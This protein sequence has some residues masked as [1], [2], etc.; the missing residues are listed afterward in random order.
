MNGDKRLDS[1][2]WE[3]AGVVGAVLLGCVAVTLLLTSARADVMLFGADSTVMPLFQRGLER[4]DPLEWQ[5]T[6]TIFAVEIPIFALVGLVFTSTYAQVLA[7]AV[8]NFVFLYAMLRMLAGIVAPAYR[9]AGRVTLA[10]AAVAVPALLVALETTQSVRTVEF[11]SMLLATSY[12]YPVLIGMFLAVALIAKMVRDAQPTA[13]A[14]LWR[15]AAL[16][17]LTAVLVT[18]NPLFAGWAVVPIALALLILLV[19]RRGVPF[20]L[21]L[22]A[23]GSMFVGA[24]VALLVR[25]WLGDVVGRDASKYMDSKMAALKY[26]RDQTLHGSMESWRGTLELVIVLALV[27]FSVYVAVLALRRRPALEVQFAA[28]V[29]PLIVLVVF[30]G[31]VFA[32]AGAARYLQPVLFAPLI[33]ILVLAGMWRQSRAEPVPTRSAWPRRVAVAAAVLLL[34]AGTASVARVVTF[35]AEVRYAATGCL[36]EWLDGRPLTGAGGFWIARPMAAFGPAD[37]QLVQMQP[38][39]SRQLWMTN[40]YD[41]EQDREITYLVVEQE[42]WYP[43]RGGESDQA[44]IYTKLLGAPREIIA[45]DAENYSIYD[46]S[47]TEGAEIMTRTLSE[48]RK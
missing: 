8:L 2:W 35:G 5:M 21:V 40:R 30:F 9:R 10:L 12:Y 11:A 28:L 13:P 36:E 18:S 25:D 41:F 6:S 4:G 14:T 20:L 27:V 17:V 24:L 7:S 47:G 23:L 42:S 45:C 29:A 39:G 37:L 33:S 43:M 48:A 16:L 15:A 26:Y 46:Y 34:V 32:G 38:D 3:L 19:V 44:E 31:S 1:R 22:I